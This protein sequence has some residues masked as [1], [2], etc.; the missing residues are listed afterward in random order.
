[1]RTEKVQM[2]KEIGNLFNDS[3]F[4]FFVTYKGLSVKDISEFR[5]QLSQQKARCHVL[6]NRLIK[7][8]AELYGPADIA[9]AGLLNDTAVVTGKGDPGM[10]AKVI[11][12]FFKKHEELSP[13]GGYMDGGLLSENDVKDIASL[14]SKEVLYSQLVGVIQAPARNLA[15]VLNNKASS[16]LNVINAYKNKLEENN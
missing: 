8:A 7:K 16:I 6:K 3:T 5:N 12:G 11:D 4:I 10:V 14:P 9:E 1:M 13:K 2:V 15:S